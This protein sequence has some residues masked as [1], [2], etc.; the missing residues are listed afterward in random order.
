MLFGQNP[1]NYIEKCQQLNTIMWFSSI[2]KSTLY[3]IMRIVC[4]ESTD[5]LKITLE[6]IFN[7]EVKYTK[8]CMPGPFHLF[9]NN[10]TI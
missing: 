6:A 8:I 9:S 4:Q 2:Y 1:H 3:L 5:L 10:L 7:L